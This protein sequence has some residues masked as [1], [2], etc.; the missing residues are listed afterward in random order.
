MEERHRNVRLW[1]ETT[2]AGSDVPQYEISEQTVNTL[3]H[4]MTK[5]EQREKYVQL[6]MEDLLQKKQE[7][8]AEAERLRQ[9]LDILNLCPENLPT[10]IQS[11]LRTLSSMALTLELSDCSDTC[12][13]LGISELSQSIHKVT[14]ERL[15]EQ[16]QTALLQ[17]KSKSAL[18][19]TGALERSFQEFREEAE[20]KGP[21][22]EK[23]KKD[24]RFIRNKEKEYHKV[25]VKNRSKLPARFTTH[26]A[27]LAKSQELQ[28]IN[29]KLSS[30]KMKLDNYHSLPPN[31]ALTKVKIEE[32]KRELDAI[33]AEL[34]EMV[35][36]IK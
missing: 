18:L 31:V 20:T 24:T 8:Q 23:K 2:F 13:L 26:D 9:T 10:S 15:F 1:L 16:K 12:Y 30:L 36:M 28:S 5:N 29:E 35:A 22:L 7:Y 11:N 19:K 27:I 25:I 14:E 34:T 32:T 3:Y 4:I 21:F 17:S 33:E 6:Q